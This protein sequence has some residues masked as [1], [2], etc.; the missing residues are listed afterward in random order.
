MFEQFKEYIGQ[1]ATL[2]E[3]DYAKIEAV[4]IFKKL[5]KKQ[6]LLQEGD[7][8]KYNAFITKGLVR[9]YS[10]DE[11]GREN[12]VSFAKENWWTGDRASLLTGEPSKNNIDAIEDT[13]L[14]LIT[15][16]NFDRLCRDI[17][18]FN[19]MVNAILNKSFIT[20]QNRIHSA[21]AFTA[22]QKYLD[23]V[24]KYPDLSLRVPQAMIASYLG[25][26]PETLSRVRKETLKKH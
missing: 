10:V 25:I 24:Q 22:E 14:I 11:N 21:I 9:F 12:I 6:Y 4:C 5:R 13:E 15:K 8:W 16:A 17:P 20:S 19:D 2:T 18:A 1:K 23:F 26:T 7:V 3:A